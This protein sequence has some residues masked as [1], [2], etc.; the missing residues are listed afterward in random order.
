MRVKDG[1]RMQSTTH[2]NGLTLAQLRAIF[3]ANKLS[4]GRGLSVAVIGGVPDIGE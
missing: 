3:Q 1:R 2:G 4:T